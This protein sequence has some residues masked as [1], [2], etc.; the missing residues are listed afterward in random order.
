[1]NNKK[2]IMYK[3]ILLTILFSICFSH[4]CPD[5]DPL[6]YGPCDM[7]LGWA[8]SGEDCEGVSGCSTENSIYYLLDGTYWLGVPSCI[9][10]TGGWVAGEN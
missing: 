7:W 8:W 2:V 3:N 9:C 4:N 1:M 10:T 5:I 6:D